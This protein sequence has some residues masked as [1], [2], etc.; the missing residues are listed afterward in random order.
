MVIIII[1]LNTNDHVNQIYYKH[2]LWRLTFKLKRSFCFIFHISFDIIRKG[3]VST[4]LEMWHL[5][6]ESFFR[7]TSLIW[8]WR[9]NTLRVL[10]WLT[11]H[12]NNVSHCSV[13][14]SK[15]KKNVDECWI[16]N[17]ITQ[18]LWVLQLDEKEMD[19]HVQPCLPLLPFEIFRSKVTKLKNELI[20]PHTL[21]L[22]NVILNV[23]A[24][25]NEELSGLLINSC[26]N[27]EKLPQK[28]KETNPE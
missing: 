26:N 10:K 24:C 4:S 3:E 12:T 15:N 9:D 13:I 1:Y 17:I 19:D 23:Y 25:A 14:Y 21:I 2:R 18:F 16:L 6:R 27:S 8:I 7:I 20:P 22:H 28:L 11:H 5:F